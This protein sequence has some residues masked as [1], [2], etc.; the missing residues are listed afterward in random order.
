LSV[1][2]NIGPGVADPYD[3]KHIARRFSW[4]LNLP[5]DRLDLSRGRPTSSKRPRSPISPIAA[6]DTPLTKRISRSSRKGSK[7][8]TGSKDHF[9]RLD[10]S[11]VARDPV[12]AEGDQRQAVE[13]FSTF[14]SIQDQGVE[15]KLKREGRK[16]VCDI[17]LKLDNIY[18]KGS[19]ENL[20]YRLAPEKSP[21]GTALNDSEASRVCLNTAKN[22]TSDHSS[23]ISEIASR[24]SESD[25]STTAEI[26]QSTHR[27]AESMAAII[28]ATAA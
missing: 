28:G 7:D 18:G 16:I 21:Q 1:I 5:Q 9:F 22:Y 17:K 24:L 2:V 13:R 19:G 10:G 3:I 11:Q 4:G 12:S 14:G 23:E 27:M 15:D 6:D 25:E 8:K 26:G 20:Y